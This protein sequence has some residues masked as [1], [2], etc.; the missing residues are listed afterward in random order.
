ME[1]DFIYLCGPTVYNKV[2]IGNMRPIVTF[3]LILRGLKYLNNNIEFIHNITDIDDKIINQAQK[4]NIL[5]ELIANKYTDFYFQMLKEYNVTTV[6]FFP[7]VS[8]KINQIQDFIQKLIDLDY[9]YESNN[10]Y[11]FRTHKISTYGEISNNLLDYLKNKKDLDDKKENPYDFVVW[12]NKT[13]GKVWDTTLGLGRPGWHTECAAFIYEKTK[14]KSLLIHGGGI[15]LKFPHHENENAQFKALTNKSI[16]SN[17]IHVGIINY[18][19]QKMSKS[20]GNIVYADDFLNKYKDKTNCSDLFRL[21]ILSSSINSTIELNDQMIDS[22]IKK[23][24]QIN[25]IVNFVLLND[26]VDSSSNF[27]DQEIIINL[28]QGKFSTIYK[29]LNQVIKDFNSSKNQ[30]IALELFWLISFLGFTCVENKITKEDINIYK[31]WQIELKN[32]NFEKAD[33]L[34]KQLLDKGLI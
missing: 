1:K 8:E 15:D 3:D 32:K 9:V 5:E 22:L 34:R 18:K 2:H 12:K 7:R 14:G 17:W 21:M 19:N 11:Y 27:I 13:K 4:E 33:Y 28:S 24:N 29:K 16:C 6:D 30:N 31:T 20:L 25:K 10:S 23:N 26:L